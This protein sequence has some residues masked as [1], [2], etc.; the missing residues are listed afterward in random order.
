MKK[1]FS[2]LG[3][4]ISVILMVAIIMIGCNSDEEQQ[5]DFSITNISPA[6]GAAGT[7]VTISGAGFGATTG[8]VKIF[9]NNVEGSV[10]SVTNSEMIATA[11]DGGTSGP[12][13]VVIGERETSGP[14]FTYEVIPDGIVST[15]AGD[16][17]FGDV[18]GNGTSA[19]FASPMGVAVDADGNVYVADQ[20]NHKIKKISEAGLVSTLAGSGVKGDADGTGADAQ[21]DNPSDVAVD[22]S[23]NVYVADLQNQKIRKI[24]ADGLVTTLAGSGIEGDVDG[25]G[26]SAQFDAPLGIAVDASGNVYVADADNYKIRIITPAGEVSTLAGNGIEGDVNGTGSAARFRGTR[27][28]AVDANGNVYVADANNHKIKRITPAGEV[29]TFAG[30]G[31]SGDGEGIGTAA[32]LNRPSD[33]AVDADGNVYVADLQNEKIRKITSAGAVSTLAGN[34]RRGDTDGSAAL[35]RFNAPNGVTVDASGNVYVADTNNHKIR[36]MAQE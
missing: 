20:K 14:V 28:V 3:S 35:A 19:Q 36:K 10:S 11:P 30:S 27:G 6:S 32:Q 1:Q 9:F 8:N 24:T 34:G 21:F 18:L 2:S 25:P 17:T 7:Q 12:I 26:A 31:D 23:G 15:L 13:K 22:A 5:S 33:V 4:I 16:G 29:S